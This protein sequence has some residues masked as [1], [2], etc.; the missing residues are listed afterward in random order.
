MTERLQPFRA[1]KFLQMF[2]FFIGRIKHSDGCPLGNFRE[3]RT[4]NCA[5]RGVWVIILIVLCY[6][7]QLT[8]A[9]QKTYEFRDKRKIDVPGRLSN[10]EV[11]FVP[12]STKWPGLIL[13]DIFGA[14]VIKNTGSEP[15]RIKN[16]M[17]NMTISLT[18]FDGHPL[19]IEEVPHPDLA[20]VYGGAMK[21]FSPFAVAKLL[22]NSEV[23][24]MPDLDGAPIEIPGNSEVELFLVPRVDRFQVTVKD[25]FASKD[26]LLK[27]LGE[28]KIPCLRFIIA[29]VDLDGDIKYR[30]I[31][32]SEPIP[33]V[34]K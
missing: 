24:D 26:T 32:M 6:F 23:V 31:L 20:H 10:L 16:P 9:A 5:R 15:I 28:L 19:Q 21:P 29:L 3:N 14:I 1:K 34:E 27:S 30:R 13:P 12:L 18:G 8:E 22:L 7:V 17:I 2:S 11:S 25:L 4:L 33:L